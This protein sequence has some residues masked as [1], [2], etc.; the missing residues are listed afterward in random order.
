MLKSFTMY[1]NTVADPGISE[2]VACSQRGMI[3]GVW[4]LF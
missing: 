3:L 2:P 4:G 1:N